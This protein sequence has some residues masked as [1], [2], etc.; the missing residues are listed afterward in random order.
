VQFD[1]P[2]FAERRL[3]AAGHHRIKTAGVLLAG[4][5]IRDRMPTMTLDA[6]L[7]TYWHAPYAYMAQ[8][9]RGVDV[10]RFPLTYPDPGGAFFGYDQRDRSQRGAET[11]STKALVATV[12]WIATM[13][14]GFR[15]G[16]MVGTKAESV[17]IYREAIGDGWTEFV[18]R[19]YML[20][21]ETWGYRI[22]D[23]DAEREQLHDLCARMLAFENHYLIIYHDWLLAQARRRDTETQRFVAARLGEVL[24]PD[25]AVRN[26]LTRL[27]ANR[28]TSVHDAA[29]TALARLAEADRTPHPLW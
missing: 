20:G 12:C 2:P 7:R 21:K 13:I 29:A 24:Y 18:A 27:A 15:A 17:H 22:P 14:V 3:L 10:L 25:T 8:V 19:I 1:L 5:D 28:D 9:L 6:Y 23:G 11:R 26:A 16:S 4:A